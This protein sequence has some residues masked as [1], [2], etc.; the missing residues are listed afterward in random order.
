MVYYEVELVTYKVKFSKDSNSTVFEMF[1]K[2]IDYLAKQHSTR[3][4]QELINHCRQDFNI[5]I[6]YVKTNDQTEYTA[7]FLDEAHYF[8]FALK[9]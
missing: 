8:W 1:L 6:D 4:P 5:G 2:A 3:N 9:W 7:V